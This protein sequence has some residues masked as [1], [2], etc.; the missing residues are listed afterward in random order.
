[1]AGFGRYDIRKIKIVMQDLFICGTPFQLYLANAIRVQKNIDECTV[2][3]LGDPHHRKA[4]HYL[5]TFPETARI[6]KFWT[7]KR[8]YGCKSEDIHRYA[9]DIAAS[10]PAVKDVYLSNITSDFYAFLLSSL[11]FDT[12]YSFDDGADNINPQ[13]VLFQ[14]RHQSLREACK[15]FFRYRFRYALKYKMH[16]HPKA[17]RKLIAHHYT[18]FPG[19]PNI[20]KNTKPIHQTVQGA[21]ARHTDGGP[22]KPSVKILLGAYFRD[23]FQSHIGMDEIQRG[24]QDFCRRHQIDYCLPHPRENC[25]RLDNT[26]ETDLLAEEFI[27][28]QIAEGHAVELYGFA[29]TTQLILDDINPPGLVNYIIESPDLH[30][31]ISHLYYEVLGNKLQSDTEAGTFRAAP[32]EMPQ[33]TLSYA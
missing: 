9:L 10:L 7:D 14:Y 11:R 23:M 33:E 6:V 8:F 12:L 27:L 15:Y 17:I 30:P 32:I 18:V 21:L 24:L 25:I 16:I 29:G 13:S 3:Y 1:M 19:R 20:V 26:V 4:C 2:L 31:K 28:S 22:R 5:G